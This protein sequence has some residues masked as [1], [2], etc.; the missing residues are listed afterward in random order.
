MLTAPYLN[1]F[2][3][4]NAL[5][6]Y[7]NPDL[8]PPLPLVEIPQKLN[9]FYDDG[10]RI[11]AKLMTTLPAKNV[12]SLPALSLLSSPE[13]SSQ[14]K[15]IVEYSSGS[16][17]MSISML[18][19]I[20]HGI[21]DTHSYLSNKADLKKINLLRFFGLKISLFSGPS[22]PEPDDARGGIMRAQKLGEEDETVYNPNQYEND[23]NWKAHYQWTGPQILKQM[24]YLNIF[25]AGIGTSGTVTGVGL[26]LKKHRPEV[27]RVG[28]NNH[29]TEIVPGTRSVPLME[30]VKFPWR[31]AVDTIEV[32]G[33]FDSYRLSLALSREGLLVGPS[34]G[35]NLQGL[36]DFLKRRKEQNSLSSLAGEDGLIHA[37]FI[38]CDL[39][40]QYLEDYY[41]KLPSSFFPEITNKALLKVDRYH[42]DKTWEAKSADLLPD[43]YPS[44]KSMSSLADWYE[45]LSDSTTISDT[46]YQ[47]LDLRTAKDFNIWH[48]P[49]AIS[50]P[51]VSLTAETRNPF[52]DTET[53]E[54]IWSE[55][56]IMFSSHTAKNMAGSK[57]VALICYDGDTSRVATSI[58]RARGVAA[59][60]LMG[61]MNGLA[62]QVRGLSHLK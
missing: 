5:R 60:N 28:V 59:V 18:A 22:Q 46:G 34:S 45:A 21:E 11:Y 41:E 12:K 26:Y 7:Y 52:F 32:V 50:K 44:L 43:L 19:R 53:M 47:I 48:L 58:L 24:P 17:I 36:L 10:V 55:L 14:T 57:K 20:L 54:V 33:S 38:C 42:Y 4:K 3:G 23:L 39:P 56:M 27:F 25:C 49:G 2:S 35:L 29:P 16:T 30:P 15:R 40:Y 13:I 9:P 6:D 37:V 51:L 1:V 31:E 8:Q 61:G 62:D